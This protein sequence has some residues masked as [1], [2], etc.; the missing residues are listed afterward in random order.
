ML[1]RVLLVMHGCR[2]VSYQLV[3]LRLPEPRGLRWQTAH[4]YPKTQ[5]AVNL[6][7]MTAVRVLLPQQDGLQWQI[8]Q[9][10]QQSPRQGQQEPEQPQAQQSG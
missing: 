6:Y 3:A 10:H 8:R 4:R 2:H 1:S 9:Q 5:T 7:R